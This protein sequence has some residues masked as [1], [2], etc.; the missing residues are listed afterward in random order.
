MKQF[1]DKTESQISSK[2]IYDGKVVHLYVDQVRL[3]DGNPALREYV[4][5][6]GAVCVLPLTNEGD[7][8]CVRQ[9]RYPFASELI[10]IPAGKLDAPDEDHREAALRELGE[11]TGAHCRSLTYLGKYYSSPAI[12]DE[13]IDMFLAEDL[14]MG[15]LDLDD[16]EFLD[17]VKIPLSTLVEMVLAG[18]VPDGKTQVAV[19]RVHELLRRRGEQCHE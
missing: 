3:P 1:R 12:L 17:L 13:C 16:D 10:E 2:L 6:I 5:H 18:E 4:R 8:L 19:M 15:E 7:V 9:Y 14:T 11:E